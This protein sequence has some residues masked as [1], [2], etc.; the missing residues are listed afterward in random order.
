[1]MRHYICLKKQFLFSMSLTNIQLVDSRTLESAIDLLEK[2]MR[3]HDI[4]V[5][6]ADL[7]TVTRRLISDRRYGFML[8]A[9][10][11][12][13]GP[14]GVAYAS[15]ILSLEHGGISGWLEELYVLPKWRGQGIGS[16]LIA[17]VV[18]LAKEAGWRAL[19]LE[20]EASHKRAISLYTRH[21]FQPRSRS[22]FYRVL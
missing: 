8:V 12:D 22:R 1:M 6:R 13:E 14:I 21:Q 2:Q 5:S 9:T 19:D 4:V 18:A 17:E 16:R 7:Q 3:E 11:I 10:T 15:S 20:V